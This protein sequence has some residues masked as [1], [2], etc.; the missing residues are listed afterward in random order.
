MIN[1][2]S[3]DIVSKRQQQQQ[4][5]EVRVSTMTLP[6][7]LPSS[8]S[9]LQAETEKQPASKKKGT[10]LGRSTPVLLCRRHVDLTNLTISSGSWNDWVSPAMA[11]HQKGRRHVQKLKAYSARAKGASDKRMQR[12][13]RLTSLVRATR[14]ID[15]AKEGW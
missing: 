1:D 5:A 3:S 14:L 12:K 8:V 9:P 4:M 6:H 7:H 11:A 15:T 13:R 2:Q 10:A